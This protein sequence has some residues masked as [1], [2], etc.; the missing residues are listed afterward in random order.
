MMVVEC[1]GS[2]ARKQRTAHR[3]G[4]KEIVIEEEKEENVKKG[5]LLG[6]GEEE[7]L[8]QEFLRP[9]CCLVLLVVVARSL[10]RDSRFFIPSSLR[11]NVRGIDSFVENTL[12]NM[13]L[14]PEIKSTALKYS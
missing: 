6:E 14:L 8:F 11:R 7:R 9:P 3:N 5:S 13:A 4:R 10:T 2:S 1:D 12:S